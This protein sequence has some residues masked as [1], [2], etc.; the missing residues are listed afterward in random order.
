[1]VKSLFKQAQEG[2]RKF[3][4]HLTLIDMQQNTILQ[5]RKIKYGNEDT[6]VSMNLQ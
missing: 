1:M 4:I 2:L 3:R 5:A 6:V